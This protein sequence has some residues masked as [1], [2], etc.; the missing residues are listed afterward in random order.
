[1]EKTLGMGVSGK[2]AKKQRTHQRKKQGLP[3]DINFKVKSEFK[4]EFKL[5]VAAHDMSQKEVLETAF[6]ALEDS[7]I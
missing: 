6:Q 1:M 3:V 7:H 4:R 2:P 5:W